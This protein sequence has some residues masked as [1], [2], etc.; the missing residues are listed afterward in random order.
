MDFAKERFC[1]LSCAK[2]VARS[3]DT[4]IIARKFLFIS[5]DS[6]LHALFS[7]VFDFHKTIGAQYYST[8][9]KVPRTNDS[10]LST[11]LSIAGSLVIPAFEFHH[12]GRVT[13]WD[14][15]AIKFGFVKLQVSA[16]LNFRLWPTYSQL[17]AHES[18]DKCA[19]WDRFQFAIV[20][21]LCIVGFFFGFFWFSSIYK[22]LQPKFQLDAVEK[23]YPR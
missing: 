1:I 3:I 9:A 7:I 15:E 14:F 22:T 20:F 2:K 10:L 13:H 18:N 4:L 11:P 6:Y 21:E 19:T 17:R 12:N 16:T 8:G 5:S 23:S